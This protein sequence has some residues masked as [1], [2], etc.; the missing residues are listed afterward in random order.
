M[1]TVMPV[2]VRRQGSAGRTFALFA[3]F[4]IGQKAKGANYNSS[5]NSDMDF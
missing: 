5:I 3:Y 4:F 1:K 2:T